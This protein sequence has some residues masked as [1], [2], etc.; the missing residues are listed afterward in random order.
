MRNRLGLL[1]VLAMLL[2][3]CGSSKTGSPTSSQKT[4][5]AAP[6]RAGYLSSC[7]RERGKS[8]S[9]CQCALQKLEASVP[10]GQFRKESVEA[11]VQASEPSS[12]VDR[13]VQAGC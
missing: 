10:E 4:S 8:A 7:S 13:Q 9:K 2:A 5:Y 6:L 11:L 12:R 3:G 1:L